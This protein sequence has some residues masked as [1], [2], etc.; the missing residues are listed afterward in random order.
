M[1]IVKWKFM[2]WTPK[3]VVFVNPLLLEVS[4]AFFKKGAHQRSR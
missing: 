3:P 2:E 1:G 4:A